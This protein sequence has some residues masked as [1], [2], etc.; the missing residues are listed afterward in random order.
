MCGSWLMA[1][2]QNTVVDGQS[3]FVW[4]VLEKV[5]ISAFV[6]ACLSETECA[7]FSGQGSVRRE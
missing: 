5:K 3:V 1:D 7:N 6:S 2:E 4:R